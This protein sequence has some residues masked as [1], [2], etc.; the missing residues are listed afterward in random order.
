MGETMRFR[1]G[2]KEGWDIALR[3]R[4]PV[5]PLE[6]PDWMAQDLVPLNEVLSELWTGL[7]RKAC[8]SPMMS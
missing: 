6:L 8:G 7:T 5:D 3:H 2:L 1:S 4:K